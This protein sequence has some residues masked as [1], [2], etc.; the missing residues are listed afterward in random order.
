MPDIDLEPESYR[1]R[2]AHR[3]ISTRRLQ[4]LTTLCGIWFA[5]VITIARWFIS[6]DN[7]WVVGAIAFAP[8]AVLVVY[9]L[10]TE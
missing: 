5:T 10:R 2:G 1:V 7:P 3:R 4:L 9:L 6:G 8:L